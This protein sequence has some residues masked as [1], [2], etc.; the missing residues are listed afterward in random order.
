MEEFFSLFE[1]S[2]SSY[3]TRLVWVL[4]ASSPLSPAPPERSSVRLLSSGM[5]SLSPSGLSSLE[6]VN[7]FLDHG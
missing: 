2:S 3:P 6:T 5:R 4:V 1:A 7:G